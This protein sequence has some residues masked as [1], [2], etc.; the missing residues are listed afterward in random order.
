MKIQFIV[1]GWWFDEFDSKTNQTAFI[2]SLQQ[3][4]EQNELIE[5]FWACHREPPAIVRDSFTYEVY[6]NIGLEWG[7]YNKGFNTLQ[8]SDDTFIFFIQDDME[9][10]DWSFINVCVE[11]LLKGT[12]VVGNGFNYPFLLSP[13]SEARLS[14]WLKSNDTWKDYVREENKHFFSEDINCFSI[15][16]SFLAT[17]AANIRRIGGFEYID[18]PLEKGIKEDGTEFLLIDPYGN[19]ALYLNAYKFVKVFGYDRMKWM[20]NTYRRSKWMTEC[21]RGN[22]DLPQDSNTQPFNVPDN[23][24]LK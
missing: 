13:N 2:E 7:A 15:R 11:A 3:L 20:S 17:T 10:Y 16:G 1:C 4:Q 23:F 22:V 24:I 12:A 8:P 19:T 18:R 5:V 9:V 6:E 14:Y 21:G